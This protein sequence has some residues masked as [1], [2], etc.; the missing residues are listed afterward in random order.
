M[1]KRNIKSQASLEFLL[2]AGILFF[3]FVIMIG[4]VSYNLSSANK[5]KINL[6]GEDVVIKVQKEINLAARVVDGYFREFY[7]P[8]KLGS[9]EYEIAIE[10]NEVIITADYGNYWRKI[11]NV[12][13]NVQ[14]GTNTIRKQNGIIYIN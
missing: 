9:K 14:K 10:R 13:G 5:K 12:T 2:L 8:Q 1:G 7:L 6:I 4:I 3:V 11:P